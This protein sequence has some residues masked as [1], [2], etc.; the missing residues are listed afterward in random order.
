MNGFSK[1]SL[2]EDMQEHVQT[3]EMISSRYSDQTSNKQSAVNTE[4]TSYK[5]WWLHKLEQH[6]FFKIHILPLN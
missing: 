1:V 2:I 5:A 6:I 3:R 4:H